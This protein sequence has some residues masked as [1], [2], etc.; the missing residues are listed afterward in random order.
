MTFGSYRTGVALDNVQLSVHS[1][2]DAVFGTGFLIAG[3]F[4]RLFTVTMAH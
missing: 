4:Y 3:Y 1:T 2:R